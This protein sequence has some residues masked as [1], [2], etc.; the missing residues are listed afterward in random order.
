DV[1]TKDFSQ[2][3]LERS[4]TVPVV[5]DFWAPWC[6]PCRVLGPILDSEIAALGGRV[7]LAKVNTDESSEL[8]QQFQIQG[9]PAVKAFR[10]GKVVSEFVGAQPAANVRR[11]LQALAPPPGVAALAAAEAALQAATGPEGTR[12]ETARVVADAEQ[13]IRGLL[14]DPGV[15]NRARLLLARLLATAGKADEARA[16][17]AT[18]DPR[19]QEALEAPAI[20]RR[21]AFAT[22]AYEYGGEDRAQ[23]ALAADPRDLEARY[24]LASALA[25]RG[26]FKEA[27]E[28]LLEIAGRNRKFRD[29]GARLAILALFDQLGHEHELTQEFRR[30]LQ[31]VL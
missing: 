10:D 25:A 30:R 12:P 13:T 31:I 16:T 19:S 26:A 11:F 20:E 5:V 7:E 9:I 1:S 22:A 8:A 6:G 27:F 3:V 24:A 23:A 21:L 28:H 29:D 18:I 15:A 17:L 4:K 14:D 2:A